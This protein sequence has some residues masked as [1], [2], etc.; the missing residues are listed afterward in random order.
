MYAPD[1]YFIKLY[2]FAKK[3]YN[4]GGC[5]DFNLSAGAPLRCI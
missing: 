3:V 2:I 5:S 4:Y 1:F